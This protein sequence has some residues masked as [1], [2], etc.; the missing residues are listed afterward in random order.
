MTQTIRVLIIEGHTLIAEGLYRILNAE[1]DIE[2]VG[3]ADGVRAIEFTARLQ[4]DVILLDAGLNNTEDLTRRLV[5]DS[6]ASE[7]LILA[8]DC[9][10]QQALA[11]LEIGAAGY[12]CKRATV[13]DLINGVRHASRGE[14]VLAP[15]VAKGLVDQLAHIAPP[16]Q[17]DDPPEDLTE[18]EIEVLHLVCQGESDKQIADALHVSPRTVQGHLRH[19]YAKLGVH[20]RTEAMHLALEQGWVALALTGLLT[21]G[22]LNPP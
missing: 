16:G 8:H 17:G 1:A 6:N 5:S 9:E 7:V 4:A 20:S 15:T 18:R 2:V 19:I 21:L 11:L 3:I 10:V 12:L 14:M 13:A 22:H